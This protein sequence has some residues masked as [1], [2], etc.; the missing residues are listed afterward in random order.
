MAS[1]GQRGFWD[2]QQRVARL[3][4]KKPVLKR[5]SDSIPW[6]SFRQLLDQGYVQERK[7]N[8]G[9]KRID[10]LIL[11]KMLVLQ[12]LFNLSDEELEFQVN[13]R[14]SFEEFVG[15]GVMNSIPDATT[16]AFFRERLRKAGVIEE[17]FEM[18]EA[19]LRSQGLQA[20]GGQII[21][22]TLVPVP[23]QRNTREEKSEI[24]AGKLP[25]GWGENLDRLQQKD[26]DARWVK[27]NG[28]NYYGY[29]NSICIDVDHGFIR[30]YAVTPANVHDSQML[31]RLLDPENKHNYV[32]A[33]SAYSG[34]CFEDLLSL[35]G[36]ESLIHEKGARNHP[37]GDAAKEL[38]RVK[39]AIRACV[40]HVFGC[41]TMSMGGKLTR[42]IGLERNEAWWGLKNLTFNFLRYLQRANHVVMAS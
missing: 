20:R 11:F 28:I 36:F 29:K 26:L 22:A 14:W 9:R 27:K 12:Q 38:N 32:W 37:L 35:G 21:D 19:Y 3:Q 10:P 15:L 18:F 4:E 31:P 34:E 1:V 39:S 24:K 5:L 30:R 42:K 40:E 13:D 41:M 33:D 25:E 2:E 8:A 17:L 16:V 6:E 23:K 7:S